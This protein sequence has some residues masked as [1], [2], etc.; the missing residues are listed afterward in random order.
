MG[1]KG[2]RPSYLH[3]SRT[4]GRYP[5]CSESSQYAKMTVPKTF[6]L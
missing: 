3:S 1:G 2:D 4:S 5:E 6:A